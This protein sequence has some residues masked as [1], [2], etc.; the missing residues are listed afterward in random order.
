MTLVLDSDESLVSISTP[1][2]GLVA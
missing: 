1:H 2:L